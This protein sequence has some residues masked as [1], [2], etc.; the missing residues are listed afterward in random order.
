MISRVLLWPCSHSLTSLV[1]TTTSLAL[2]LSLDR[3]ASFRLLEISWQR[4]VYASQGSLLDDA[5]TLNAS[6]IP[7]VVISAIICNYFPSPTSTTFA[8]INQSIS[9]SLS[10]SVSLSLSRLEQHVW[11]TGRCCM[12]RSYSCFCFAFATLFDA[13]LFTF[14]CFWN[15]N[16]ND[17]NVVAAMIVL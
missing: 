9:L 12:S 5:R 13:L 7:V 3:L 15:C 1:L 16:D 4:R 2:A 10:L 17:N 14:G 8:S 6:A 11:C